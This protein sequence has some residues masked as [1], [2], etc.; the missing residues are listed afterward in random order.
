MPAMFT[1]SAM[2]LFSERPIMQ[3]P[4]GRLCQFLLQW[5]FLATLGLSIGL[6]G[7]HARVAASSEPVAQAKPRSSETS[8]ERSSELE[9]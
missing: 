4:C 6:A 1:M 7:M 2:Q 9:R 8:D 5:K 3:R